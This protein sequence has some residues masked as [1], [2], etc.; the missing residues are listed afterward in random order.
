MSLVLS[1]IQAQ[2]IQQME[3]VRQFTTICFLLLILMTT[4]V[5]HWTCPSVGATAQDDL[6]D[7]VN[8]FYST[9]PP[10]AASAAATSAGM[11]DLCTVQ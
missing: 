1:W 5:C 4:D 6:Q 2:A 10:V 7:I 11:S 8:H 9:S 3:H